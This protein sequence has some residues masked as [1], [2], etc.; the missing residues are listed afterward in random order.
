MNAFEEDDQQT[1]QQRLQQALAS[2]V[3]EAIAQ[4]R[5]AARGKLRFQTDD[6]LRACVALARMARLLIADI[7]A[8]EPLQ[9]LAHPDNTPEENHRLLGILEEGHR[10]HAARLAG[11]TPPAPTE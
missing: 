10:A 4:L 3:L 9:S 8:P 6:E 2:A 1:L 7:P 5:T 11:E